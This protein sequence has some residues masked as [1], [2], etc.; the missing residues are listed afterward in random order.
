MADDAPKIIVD[1]DWKSEA[2]AERKRL[3]EQEAAA[4]P[5]A[6]EGGLPPADFRGLLGML[7]SQALMYMGGAADQSGRAIFD[8]MLSQH[9]IDLL[10]VLENK[11]K[12]NLTDEEATELSGVLRELR[13]RYVE[14]TQLMAEQQQ[15]AGGGGGAAPGI[16]T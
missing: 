13:S 3:A 7:A 15:Q 6:G 11:T 1:S 12:G 5:G 8:P 14:L 9:L 10:G 2:E 16:V 4:Q